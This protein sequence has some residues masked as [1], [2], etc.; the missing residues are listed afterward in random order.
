[1]IGDAVRVGGAEGPVDLA[2]SGSDAAPGR[3]VESGVE[4]VDFHP[5]GPG[6]GLDELPD[7]ISPR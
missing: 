3:R 1:M 7:P 2:G 5:V 6:L 4:A